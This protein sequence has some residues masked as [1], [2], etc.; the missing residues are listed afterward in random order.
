MTEDTK[1]T[2]DAKPQQPLKATAPI[3]GA[4]FPSLLAQTRDRQAAEKEARRARYAAYRFA[5]S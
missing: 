4:A 3:E 5:K 2:K 1:T